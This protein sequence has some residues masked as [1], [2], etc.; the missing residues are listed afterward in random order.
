ML[1]VAALMRFRPVLDDSGL[2]RPRSGSLSVL[3]R[4]EELHIRAIP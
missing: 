3:E 2:G 4:T 1:V